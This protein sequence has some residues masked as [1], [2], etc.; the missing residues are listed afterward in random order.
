MKKILITSPILDADETLVHVY[1]FSKRFNVYPYFANYLFHLRMFENGIIEEL[2]KKG[3]I[4]EFLDSKKISDI[5][6]AKRAIKDAS[7]IFHDT[8]TFM[9]SFS[10]YL[11]HLEGITK[12]E[13]ELKALLSGY[14]EKT[15]YRPYH[16]NKDSFVDLHKPLFSKNIYHLIEGTDILFPKTYCS[17]KEI[18]YPCIAKKLDGFRGRNIFLLN[19]N[20]DIVEKNL[21]TD[22]YVFQE[23]IEG[24]SD[25][26][27]YLIFVKSLGMHFAKG[28]ISLSYETK[29]SET[30]A[31]QN[32]GKRDFI[33]IYIEPPEQ[34]N[35]EHEK[36][37][38]RINLNK[39][40]TIPSSLYQQ[41]LKV[42]KFFSERG[43]HNCTFDFIMGKDGKFYFLEANRNYTISSLLP[44][45]ILKIKRSTERKKLYRKAAC[46]MAESYASVIRNS[47]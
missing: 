36:V 18:K 35:Q 16:L 38:E 9:V 6:Y 29:K 28:V 22:E 20:D 43:V 26:P 24:P 4:I 40:L 41:F 34:F 33:E 30:I 14:L 5:S 1:Q 23:I 42:S 10:R 44:N 39:D 19:S 32:Y 8:I 31:V 12:L 21:N 37:M 25:I 17:T 2:N 13:E 45:L 47:K 7:M 3:F 11:N 15:D 46:V 27:F